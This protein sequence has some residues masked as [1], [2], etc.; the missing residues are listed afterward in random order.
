MRHSSNLLYVIIV[1]AFLCKE[2][3]LT[4]PL[5]IEW[6]LEGEQMVELHVVRV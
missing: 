2:G 4:D 3:I 6:C 1:F 5:D